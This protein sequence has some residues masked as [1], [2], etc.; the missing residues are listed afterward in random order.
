MS[1]LARDADMHADQSLASSCT[2]YDFDFIDNVVCWMLIVAHTRALCK[3]F[4]GVPIDTC[5]LC[6]FVAVSSH[7]AAHSTTTTQLSTLDECSGERILISTVV[8]RAR[9]A[10]GRAIYRSKA[11]ISVR[12]EIMIVFPI[13]ASDRLSTHLHATKGWEKALSVGQ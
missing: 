12:E 3:R 13:S 6:C 7:S 5:D 4:A 11:M 1:I 9:Q 10:L 8:S 2:S